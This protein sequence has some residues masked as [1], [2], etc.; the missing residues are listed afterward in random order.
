VDLF[1]SE[2]PARGTAVTD[3]EIR[4]DFAILQELGVTGVRF[5]HFQHPQLAYEE[6]D[7]LGL[8]VW[9]EIPLNGV[10]DPGP[11]FE[12]NLEQQAEEL[13][14]QNA[15]H[16]SVAVWGLGN[17][18]YAVNPDVNR[19]LAKMQQV[20]KREDPSRPTTYA[21]CCQADD[22]EKA[23]HS[24]TIAFN[25]YF[26]WYPGQQ[27]SLGEWAENFHARFPQRAFA[28][29]EYGAGAS[30]R[31]QE[32]A[33]SQPD[34][35][36]GW[37]PEQFQTLFH[38]RSWPQIASLDYVWGKFVWVAFDLAS[39]GRAEGDRPGINDK[40]LVTYD[41]VVRKDAFFYYQAQWSREPVLHLANQRLTTYHT[42]IV[43]VT[44]FT[45]APTAQLEVNGVAAG[46]AEVH[47]GV[48]H[49]AGVELKPGV[50]E[51][52]VS[53]QSA[54]TALRDAAQWRLE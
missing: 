13:I 52:A 49:W 42:R 34:T 21:H 50:N 54:G 44:A 17:E 47:G 19:V 15:Q 29:G 37:H 48:A 27:G 40:G 4:Q 32:A 51:I 10:I 31:H 45:N 22:D 41:R 6:A 24:D 12:Q 16:P 36:G 18:V 3:D 2:R 46:T 26:G 7:R 1:H 39:D 33:P 9:T 28:I 35:A 25:R 11:A 23:Q 8:I 30:I 53:A 43:E 20:M 38:E 14:R 5:V